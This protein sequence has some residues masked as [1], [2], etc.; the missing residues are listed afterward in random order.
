MLIISLV[1]FI[2]VIIS[3]II[4]NY[5]QDKKYLITY[6][7]EAM[8]T[9][10]TKRLNLAPIN[11]GIAYSF[12]LW[13][14]I[15]NW[16]YRFGLVKPIIDWSGSG[17]NLIQQ[18]RL[19]DINSHG[20]QKTKDK[21][22]T[23]PISIGETCRGCPSGQL[24]DK[25]IVEDFANP[26]NMKSKENNDF[27][28]K[29]SLGSQKNQLLVELKLI[30][31]TQETLK[32]DNI[33]IQKWISIGIILKQ[34][35][36]DVFIN[37]KLENSLH[38]KGIPQYQPGKCQ[39]NPNGGFNGY[40][41]R[42]RH[43]NYAL[44]IL[45]IQNLFRSGPKLS[46][47]FLSQKRPIGGSG[48]RFSKDKND[49]NIDNPLI[50]KKNRL[51]KIRNLFKYGDLCHQDKDCTGELQCLNARCGYPKQSRSNQQTCLSTSDCQSGFEC[52]NYGQ[53]DLSDKQIKDLQRLGLPVDKN[54]SYN[55]QMGKNPFKCTY[56]QK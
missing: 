51:S 26:R 7:V 18:C 12:H 30:D 45:E 47:P 53:V 24:I 21:T 46:N 37:A 31:G 41:S 14:Y 55:P 29:L 23:P 43:F 50:R 25:L 9:F 10:K 5:L 13:I 4:L 2:I 8:K 27:N 33:P 56:I 54:N 36:L 28:L 35:D 17:N 52:N 11:G 19:L 48:S 20:D 42:V 39:L 6:P 38:L 16:N 49:I 44:G 34:R 40:I 15:T 22:S 3:L 1:I 32:L